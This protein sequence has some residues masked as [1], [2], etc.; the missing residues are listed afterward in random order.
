M[1]ELLVKSQFQISSKTPINSDEGRDK[2]KRLLR[3]SQPPVRNSKKWDGCFEVGHA[4]ACDAYI[5]NQCA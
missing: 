1:R 3:C 5:L 4:V 2:Q